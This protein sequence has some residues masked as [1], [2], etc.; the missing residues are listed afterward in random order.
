MS[1]TAPFALIG[2]LLG[3]LGRE[4]GEG[5]RGEEEEGSPLPALETLR[6]AAEGAAMRDG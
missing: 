2:A 3:G 6:G 4:E 1:G 5:L